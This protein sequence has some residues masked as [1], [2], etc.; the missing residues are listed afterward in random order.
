[1]FTGIIEG[2]GTIKRVKSSAQGMRISVEPDFSLDSPEIGESIAVNGVC[3]TAVKITTGFFEADVSPETLNRS[4]LGLLRVGDR[5]NLE[6]ALRL[7]D[8]LGGHL[9]SG[10]IDGVGIVNDVKKLE[11]FFLFTI[12]I[13]AKLSRY[14][15]E[16]GSI[17]IDGISLTVNSCSDSHFSVAVIP[18]TALITTM[19][20]RRA[21]D[22][23]N[24]ETDIVGKYI[25]KLMP[26]RD[27]VIKSDGRGGV[28]LSLLAKHGFL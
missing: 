17:A 13:P 16:K 1:M 11:E 28:D 3:L 12:G 18:H 22:K 5:V 19:G 4:T 20:F 27:D 2:L 9:V 21:G 15:I 25:E 23:L 14:I 24:I 6:R 10:H 26:Y 7:G 8:R